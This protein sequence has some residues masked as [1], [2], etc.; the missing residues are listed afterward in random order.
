MEFCCEEKFQTKLDFLTSET[1]K[2]E[3]VEEEEIVED[4]GQVCFTLLP[5]CLIFFLICLHRGS[6]Q[7]TREHCG[8][9]SRS[10]TNLCL[11]SI[12]SPPHIIAFVKCFTN[13]LIRYLSLFSISLVLLSTVK[14]QYMKKTN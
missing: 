3:F 11:L 1:K 13:V 5:M 14:M 10:R 2:Y 8:T 7:S 6:W 9:L 4:F 12:Y